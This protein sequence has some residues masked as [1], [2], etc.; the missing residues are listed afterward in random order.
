M[1]CMEDVISLEDARWGGAGQCCSGL[2]E[3]RTQCHN[4]VGSLSLSLKAFS[5]L[6]RSQI[7]SFTLAN[8]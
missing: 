6:S 7:R 3:G 4:E 5:I 1:V 2:P 8:K